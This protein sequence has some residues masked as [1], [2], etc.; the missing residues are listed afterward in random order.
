MM[1]RFSGGYLVGGTGLPSSDDPL[2]AGSFF[3]SV[4]HFGVSRGNDIDDKDKCLSSLDGRPYTQVGG[5]KAE[6][7]QTAKN[8][9]VSKLGM[10][11]S[12][13]VQFSGQKGGLG[14]K[15][16][17][18]ILWVFRS[19]WSSTWMIIPLGKWVSNHPS[20]PFTTGIALRF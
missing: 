16:I 12:T 20:K 18:A 11:K 1:T 4:A 17:L 6:D 8:G 10:S 5:Y 14:A 3:G 7:K 2:F 15:V 9:V 13:M 19:C